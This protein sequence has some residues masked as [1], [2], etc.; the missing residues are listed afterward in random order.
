[1]NVSQ[2][3]VSIW[4]YNDNFV[5]GVQGINEGLSLTTTILFT[6]M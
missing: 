2:Y 1:M 4:C 3:E 5:I 6:I